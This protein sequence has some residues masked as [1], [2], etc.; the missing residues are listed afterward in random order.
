M[1][2]LMFLDHQIRRKSNLDICVLSLNAVTNVSGSSNK[3]EKVT[4]IFVFYLYMQSLMFLDHQIK[5]K[6][7]WILMFCL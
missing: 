7:T 1:Q 5:E 3:G 2:S 4:W 6:V